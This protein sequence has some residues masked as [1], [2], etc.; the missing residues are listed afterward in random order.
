VSIPDYTCPFH[1]SSEDQIIALHTVVMGSGAIRERNAALD[2]YLRT[3]PNSAPADLTAIAS[4]NTDPAFRVTAIHLLALHHRDDSGPLFLS[5]LN[6]PDSAIRTAAADGIDILRGSGIPKPDNS[7][8]ATQSPHEINSDPPI[9][10]AQFLINPVYS[11]GAWTS[12][13]LKPVNIDQKA[14]ALLEMMMTSAQS[15]DE[16]EAT[17]RALVHWPPS[18]YKLRAAEWGVWIADSKGDLKLV[19][20]ILDEIPPFVHRIGNTYTSLSDRYMIYIGPVTKPIL[21]FTTDRP[22]ALD[23]EVNINKGRPWFAYPKPDDLALSRHDNSTLRTS[24]GANKDAAE[25]IKNLDNSSLAS[26]SDLRE[27]YP[28]LLPPHRLHYSFSGGL[29]GSFI[30][31]ATQLGLRWQ[32][33]IVLPN[34]APWMTSPTV[35]PDP[36][37]KWWSDLRAVPSSYLTSR[38]E[39]ERFLYYDGPTLAKPPFIATLSGK[40]LALKPSPKEPTPNRPDWDPPF[41]AKPTLTQ[42]ATPIS[43]YREAFF[44]RV[45]QGK[46]SAYRF[47]LN[48]NVQIVQEL[49]ANLPID[50][51]SILPAFKKLLTD[52]GLTPEE[53]QGLIDAWQTQFFQTEG[54]RLLL[55]L[56]ADDYDTLCPLSI[57][58]RPT[59][60]TRHGFV[61]TEL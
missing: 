6:A 26:M 37:F 55:R 25:Q 51:A 4:S 39:T 10:V 33:L 9:E 42:D 24:D 52:Y 58:P 60:H 5:L 19:Q 56:S 11:N 53:S 44:I 15:A 12:P 59:T 29:G 35:P 46:P 22:I 13:P 23:V 18:T 38:G 54:Q 16:R 7:S 36:K 50:S 47:K 43:Q 34:K 14:R 2:L 28:W 41:N 40:S 30:P 3:F 8:Y 57:D 49:P 27:G 32:S 31:R 61:Q 48:S 20:S 1:L 45:A 21:H 17:A